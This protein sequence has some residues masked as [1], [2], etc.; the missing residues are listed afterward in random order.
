MT[1]SPLLNAEVIS[2]AERVRL[3]NRA[4]SLALIA[5]ILLAFLKTSIGILGHSPALL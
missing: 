2:S 3:C 4:V 5:N 1:N